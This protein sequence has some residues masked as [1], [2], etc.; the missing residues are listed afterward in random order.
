MH[1][2][3]VEL[4]IHEKDFHETEYQQTDDCAITRALTRAGYPQL[5]DAG[6]DIVDRE[7]EGIVVCNGSS[8]KE[9]S[10][11]VL[12]MYRYLGKEMEYNFKNTFLTEKPQ[13]FTAVLEFRFPNTLKQEPE[14]V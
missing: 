2:K 10:D 12:R 6:I 8:Y 7:D 13:D 14:L 3:E 9:M 4:Q 5:R 11:R 1:I